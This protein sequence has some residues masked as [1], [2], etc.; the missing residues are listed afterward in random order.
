MLC[1]LSLSIFLNTSMVRFSSSHNSA[2]IKS[3][4]GVKE[5]GGENMNYKLL[6]LDVMLEFLP[7]L[8]KA[9][10][11]NHF[12]HGHTVYEYRWSA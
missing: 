12:L 4:R 7:T 5:K 10:M 8:E 9:H 2:V 1:S 11:H 3:R 6:K